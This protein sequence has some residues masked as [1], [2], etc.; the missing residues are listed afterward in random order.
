MSLRIL[1]IEL[2]RH[3]Y[4]GAKQVS[5]LLAA[6][7]KQFDHQNHLV[8]PKD[9]EIGSA[10]I[11]GCQ[12]HTIVYRG[13]TDIF[14]IK[15]ISDIARKINANVIHV[16]SRRGAD[17]FGALVAK[18]TGIPSICTRRV[19]N[20]ESGLAYYKYKQYAAVA[21]ISKGVY[22]VVSQHCEGVKFQ[23]IIHSA[24]DLNEFQEPSHREWLCN[25]YS[26]PRDHVIIANFAQLISRKG[27]ADIILAMEKVISINPKVTC[28]L[29]G[30]GIL[31]ESYQALIDKHRL[32]NNVK[33]CGFTQKVSKVLPS[34]DIVIHP[35]YA[36]GLGVIL[37]QAGA[38]KRAVISTPVGGIPEIII[39]EKTGL[40]VTPGCVD[41]IANAVL[42]LIDDEALR[43]RLGEQLHLHIKAGFI[44]QEMAKRYHELYMEISQQ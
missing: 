15:R 23:P 3:L 7:N 14:A 41:D 5:Y 21:S 33:L 37:L 12:L 29:F 17:V 19:D 40:M 16:H 25:A 44:P 39:H 31:Q 1:H 6:L 2:G 8:C 11:A 22:E 27:Q 43:S 9:S 38:C 34:I 20:P 28:L 13:E 4:G 35:A 26:I 18:I 36:E 10:S 32:K 42:T 30:K 24:V